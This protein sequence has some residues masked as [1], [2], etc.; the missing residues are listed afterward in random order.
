MSGRRIRVDK[1]WKN[2]R[3]VEESRKNR[4]KDE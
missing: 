4:N 2:R 1:R 3:M